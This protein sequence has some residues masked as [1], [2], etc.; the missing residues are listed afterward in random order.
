[1]IQLLRQQ[2]VFDVEFS[3]LGCGENGEMNVSG[4]QS[5]H[6][7]GRASFALGYS[8]PEWSVPA[9]TNGTLN[10]RQ[11]VPDARNRSR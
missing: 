6:N 9:W 11:V 3:V 1:M 2:L 4:G 8:D 10:M 5:E 7:T